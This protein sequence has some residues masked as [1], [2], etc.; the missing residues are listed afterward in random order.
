MKIPATQVYKTSLPNFISDKKVVTKPLD[1]KDLEED[2]FVKSEAE[3]IKSPVIE[4]AKNK[5]TSGLSNENLGTLCEM[6]MW[7]A[8]SVFLCWDVI[9]APKSSLLTKEIIEKLKITKLPE[10]IIFK[11]AKTLEEAI[12]YS[13][14]VLKI[15][16]VDSDFTLEALNWVNNGLTIASNKQKGNAKMPLGLLFKDCSR[17]KPGDVLANVSMQEEKFAYMCIDKLFFELDFLNQ[18][19]ER[20]IYKDNQK[21]F[22]NKIGNVLYSN[23]MLFLDENL[24]KLVESFYKDKNGLSIMDKRKLY[25]GFG[26]I[27]HKPIKLPFI[28]GPK[29]DMLV[30]DDDLQTIFH[31][32][33]HLQDMAMNYAKL[34]KEPFDIMQHW[35]TAENLQSEIINSSELLKEFF[36]LP[37]QNTVSK[38]STYSQKGIG[39]FI[40][41]T[42][43]FM[44]K[45]KKFDKE[46]IELYK[47]FNGPEI[48]T[49]NY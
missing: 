49:I 41:E 28:S 22:N 18:K 13:N 35:G 26:N 33:G 16:Y 17:T 38:V 5:K 36:S 34:A 32:Q 14:D 44:M 39:E 40:A 11:K 29:V 8:T 23:E 47:K 21:V 31:E 37:V 24:S 10:V 1:N 25:F 30:P 12:K 20:L 3:D 46:I 43:A 45:G 6:G 19:I 27:E 4:E 2:K 42:Y 7:L 9:F 48:A 15:P